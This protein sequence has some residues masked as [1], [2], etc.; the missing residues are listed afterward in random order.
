MFTPHRTPAQP[1]R[2]RISRREFLRYSHDHTSSLATVEAKWNLPALTFRDA[3]ATTVMDFLDLTQA[4][5]QQPPAITAP[6]APT[7]AATST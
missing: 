5:F 7:S 2:S 1:P 6:P 4:S 3:N